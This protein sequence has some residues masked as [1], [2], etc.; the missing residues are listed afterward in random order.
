MTN[1]P[2]AI[3]AISIADEAIN[4][5]TAGAGEQAKAVRA[6]LYSKLSVTDDKVKP[7]PKAS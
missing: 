7:Q 6:A 4:R 5:Q 3:D 2:S 1:R